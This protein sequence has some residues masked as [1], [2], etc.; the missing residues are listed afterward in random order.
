MRS[1]PMSPSRWSPR[2]LEHA[3]AARHSRAPNLVARGPNFQGE[4]TKFSPEIL[5][6]L[7]QRGIELKPGQGEDSG[8]T[9]VLIRNGKI[10]GGADPR[11]EGVVL[12]LLKRLGRVRAD[13]LSDVGEAFALE[14]SREARAQSDAAMPGP[15]KTIAR[16]ELDQARAR[17]ECAPTH[18]RRS[19]FRRRR[20][21]GFRR[22]SP[23]RNVRSASSASG[24][25]RRA[26]KAARLTC[27][28]D[29]SGGRASVVLETIERVDIDGRSPHG[30]CVRDRRRR[31]PARP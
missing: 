16:I 26:R 21:A 2:R 15:S 28:R 29:L 22:R 3:D 11:R 13:R 19:R 9:G 1:S 20:S 31:D 24:F 4:V 25:E 10:D 17:R 8:L 23:C 5:A 6:G 14:T 7:R 18:H 12:T 27:K 30:R